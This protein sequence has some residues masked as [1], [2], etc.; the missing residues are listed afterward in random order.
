[1][2]EIIK[3]LSPLRPALKA[4]LFD[5]DGTLSTLRCGW[6]EIM[7]PMML[8]FIAGETALDET[9]KGEVKS[10]IDRSTGIQTYYQMEWLAGEVRRLK[11]NPGASADPW[12]YKDEYNRRLMNCVMQRREKIL[13]GKASP[14]DYL[15]DGSRELLAALTDRG[16]SIYVASGTDHEDVNEEARI[17]GLLPY[18]KEVVGAP[19][20]KAEC[21]KAAVIRRMIREHQLQGQEVAVWG[22]GKVEIGL[23][24]EIQAVT[25]GVASD[26]ARRRGVNPVKRD[27]LIQAGA[28]A[29]IGDFSEKEELLDFLTIKSKWI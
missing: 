22:D 17:L 21:S 10:F 29:I 8:E 4:V 11:R 18:F 5:F 7:E 15:M 9:L 24:N 26:E 19:L 20:H 28:H 25:I 6:E 3:P 16:I 1:M 2:I 12:W 23:G 27:R 13:S 14:E